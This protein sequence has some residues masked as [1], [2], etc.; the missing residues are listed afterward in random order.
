MLVGGILQ[1]TQLFSVAPT[2]PANQQVKI[3]TPVPAP[4]QRMIQRFGLR[5]GR[6]TAIEQAC[7]TR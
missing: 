5:P 7:Q 1:E 4:R 3:Q 2:P 6:F